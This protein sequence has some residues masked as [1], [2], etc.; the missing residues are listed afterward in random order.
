MFNRR[1][2]TYCERVYSP[3]P[4]LDK[5]M[6]EE[7]IKLFSL[8]TQTPIDCFDFLAITIQYE[9]CYTN[10]LQVID[11]SNI[12]LEWQNEFLI[13]IIQPDNNTNKDYYSNI[14][15]NKGIYL[16]STDLSMQNSLI[17][18]FQF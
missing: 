9:M 17:N 3:W 15:S 6:R 14:N 5:I 10:I 11:L 16:S 7:H 2:D 18:N 4:D 13:N 12:Q 1:E 8:E